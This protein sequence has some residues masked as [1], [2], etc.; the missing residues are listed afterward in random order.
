ATEIIG[1]ETDPLKKARLLKNYVYK[2][3]RKTMACN[4]STT[5]GVLDSMAGDCTEH[6]LLFVSLAR[7]AG[8]PARELTGV[9]HVD[10][11]FGWHAWAEFHYGHQWVSVDPTWNGL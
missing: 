4:S 11:I 1:A 9:A 3:L 7:A 2:N 5:L 8:L 10:Q 6:T